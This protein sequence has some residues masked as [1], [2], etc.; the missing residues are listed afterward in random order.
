MGIQ[1]VL[2]K[3]NETVYLVFLRAIL[4]GLLL[5]LGGCATL[6]DHLHDIRNNSVIPVSSIL[7]KIGDHRVIFVGEAHDSEVDHLVQLE[8]IRRL[9][10]SGRPISIALEAF[11]AGQ[12]QK[13]DAW[14]AG[15]I[16][17]RTFTRAYQASWNVAIG[18]YA[19]IFEY[20]K[21]NGIRL[22]G[23]NLTPREIKSLIA[24]GSEGMEQSLRQAI[25]YQDCSEA[26]KY[27]K[28]MKGYWDRLGHQQGFMRMC[29]T[30]RAKEAFMA[31]RLARLLAVQDDT[32]VALVG[33]VHAQKSAIP[34]M[35]HEHGID[36]SLVL[37]PSTLSI[38]T[39]GITKAQGD[40]VW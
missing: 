9:H 36:D 10:E 12:Q 20:A 8:V 7:K 26:S 30:R 23:L 16:S 17:N 2:G 35:L 24:R 14:I 15:R 37:L 40:L 28:A 34:E 25:R 11:P 33:S 3:R 38:L 4:I 18:Y 32:V 27:T 6:P 31:Y 22:I 39:R 1:F 19:D 21:D 5:L 29:N 13:L